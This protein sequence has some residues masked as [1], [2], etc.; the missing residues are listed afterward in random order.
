MK[1]KHLTFFA[2]IFLLMS[3][4]I[5]AD[6]SNQEKI[7]HNNTMDAKQEKLTKFGTNYTSAWNSQ[8]PENVAS[9]FADNGSLVVNKGEPLRGRD[10]ITE[11]A[12]GF[13]TAFPDMKSTMYS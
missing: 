8:E 2:L 6:K 3:C 9:F 7:D 5:N 12:R 13:M 4:K 1:L 10:D 11:F